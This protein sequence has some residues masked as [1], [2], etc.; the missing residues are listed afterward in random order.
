MDARDAGVQ[1]HDPFAI[2]AEY[3]H[4]LPFF[5]LAEHRAHGDRAEDITGFLQGTRSTSG[6]M[7]IPPRRAACAEAY[8]SLESRV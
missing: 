1:L 8:G 7:A 6:R 3:C 5:D 4:F 2:V